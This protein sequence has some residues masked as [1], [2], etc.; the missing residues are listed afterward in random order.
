MASKFEIGQPT[1][2]IAQRQCAGSERRR[3]S[4][5]INRTLIC[6]KSVRV[7]SVAAFGAV[8]CA[9]VWGETSRKNRS[10]PWMRPHWISPCVHRLETKR[11]PITR[12]SGQHMCLHTISFS[13][14]VGGM[15]ST[16]IWWSFSNHFNRSSP[17]F[18]RLASN[19]N[20]ALRSS[21]VKLI[22]HMDMCVYVCVS[23]RNTIANY[24]WIKTARQ[25]WVFPV[26]IWI[27]THRSSW[28]YSRTA[29]VP[30]TS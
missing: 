13:D 10:P 11:V 20:S 23:R 21:F 22:V 3:K 27:K 28:L 1:K 4:F 6:C 7:P 12:A 15:E 2:Y 24:V 14:K 29:R 17:A 25:S 19:I 5:L 9:R 26:C 16:H 18:A 8:L 30:P